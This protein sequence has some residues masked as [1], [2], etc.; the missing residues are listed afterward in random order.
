MKDYLN[1]EETHSF[2]LIGFLNDE[3]HNIKENWGKRNFLTKDELKFI[4]YTQTYFKKF[5]ESVINRLNKEEV[6][7]LYKRL[8]KFQFRVID[9][10]T[11]KK[12]ERDINDKA[13]YAVVKREHF[14]YLCED[15]M[16]IYCKNCKTHF[17][18]CDLYK[19]FD[20]NFIPESGWDKE[21]CRYAYEEM[22]KK[23]AC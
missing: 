1:K 9:E 14:E 2:L 15:I 20:D 7:K 19:I 5:Y 3:L 12:L 23:G 4:S 21:N 16:E 17:S 8:S 18:E 22:K 11:T 10:Y 13:R 6:T